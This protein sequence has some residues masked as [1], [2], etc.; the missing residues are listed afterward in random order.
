M[1][2]LKKITAGTLALVLATGVA[3]S[4]IAQETDTGDVNVQITEMSTG[5]VLSASISDENFGPHEYSLQDQGVEGDF[6][7]NASDLRGT[8][9]GWTVTIKG[10]DFGGTNVSN[11]FSIENLGL[12]QG[13][14]EKTSISPHATSANPVVTNVAPVTTSE[15]TVVTAIAGTGAG[16][17]EAE[18]DANLNIPGGTLVGT[19]ETTLTVTI[20]GE[21]PGTVGTGEGDN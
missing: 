11:G 8:A 14:V 16:E 7:I 4:V 5:G 19:Y 20:K 13:S 18:F 9:A 1:N 2:I 10:E 15:Q 17:Y 21:D 12:A 6:T 3:G